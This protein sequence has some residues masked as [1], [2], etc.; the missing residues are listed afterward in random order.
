MSISVIICVLFNVQDNKKP[1]DVTESTK[2]RNTIAVYKQTKV[3]FLLFLTT[4]VCR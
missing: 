4:N 1:S 3:C 2:L